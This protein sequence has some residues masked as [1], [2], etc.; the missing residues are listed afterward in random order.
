[1]QPRVL[2]ALTLYPLPYGK[3]K[4]PVGRLRGGELNPQEQTK[5]SGH[6]S[7]LLLTEARNSQR[8]VSPYQTVSPAGTLTKL[9]HRHLGSEARDTKSGIPRNGLQ[10]AVT[11][12]NAK[13]AA[14]H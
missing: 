8:S 13:I 4:A 3:H 5:N 1:M 14:T 9:H 6:Q 7:P 12:G 2:D 11:Q 10:V